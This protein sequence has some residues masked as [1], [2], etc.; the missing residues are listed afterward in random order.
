M[1]FAAVASA[2]PA[3]RYDQS[4]LTRYLK[5]EVWAERP[6]ILRRIDVLHRNVGVET[7]HLAYPL[8]RYATLR[9]FGEFNDAWITAATDLGERAVRTALERA[10]LAPED[11]DA[12]F[13]STVTGV[14]SPS[15]DALLV[16]RLG[17]RA[18]VRRLPMFG[19]GCV[20]GAAAVA[21]AADYV[22]GA[23]DAVA[24][25]LTIEL[26]SLTVQRDDPSLAN[27]IA[28][29]LFGDGATCAIVVGA[30]RAATGPA[31]VDTRSVFYPD[32]EDVMGWKVRETGFELV[33]SPAVP[34]VAREHLGEDVARFLASRDLTTKDVRSW[35]C[36]PGGP[37][38]L[39][40]ARDALG[41]TDDDLALSWK[42]LRE[43]G[44]LSSASVLLILEQTMA[45]RR[46]EPGSLGVMLA[47]GPGFCSELLLLRW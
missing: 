24:I 11:V 26:C 7:R 28:A 20:A 39:A 46:P 43:V 15:I 5:D 29:G 1:R 27:V 12:I 16:N 41:L 9:T 30:N 17:L 44:N 19:L 22:R 47:M 33:L 23:P 36:H 31:I 25:V 38:V 6:E 37:K 8:E 42:S 3:H 35:V 4:R 40:A 34:T 21:R 45:L 2:L 13:F 32:T 18:D 10:R 14:A